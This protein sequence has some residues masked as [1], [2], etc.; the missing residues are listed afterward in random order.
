VNSLLRLRHYL[1]PYAG[2]IL[3]GIFFSIIVA[4]ATGGVAALIKPMFNDVFYLGSP[5]TAEAEATKPDSPIPSLPGSA[6]ID[7]WQKAGKEWVAVKAREW[8]GYDPSRAFIYIPTLFVLVFLVKSL[9]TFLSTYRLGTVGLRAVQDV[10]TKLYE[11]IQRQSLKFFAHHPTGLLIS[12]VTS[13]VAILQQ[14]LGTP[15][16]EIIRL[17]F[18]LVFLIAAALF[19]DWKLS[20]ICTVVIPV[21]VYPAM[22]FARKIKRST[23]TSQSRLADLAD[24][25]Q[26]TIVGRRVVRGF[27]GESYEIS[28]FRGLLDKMYV[29]DG[30]A[31]KYRALTQPV[32]ELIGSLAMA[33]LAAFAGWR[34][35]AGTLDPGDFVATLA[36]LYWM[37]AIFKHF[38]RL[39]NDMTRAAA[40]AERVFQVLDSEPDVAEAADAVEMPAFE[41]EIR[42]REACFSYAGEPVLQGIDLTIRKGEKVALVGASG[43]GK[44]TTV[45]LLPRFYDVTAGAVEIDG[46]DV[47]RFTLESLRAQIG[48]VTQEIVLFNDTARNNIAYGR[49]DVSLDDVVTAAR[50]ANAHEFLSALPSRYDTLLGEAGQN[51]SA[52]QRQRV[53]IARALLK[54]API[55]ILDEAT[56]ALDA[57]SEALVQAALDK[58]IA[59]RTAIIIA[60]RLTTVRS[61]DRIVVIENGRIAEIGTHQ[62]LLDRKGVYARLHRLQFDPAAAPPP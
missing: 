40:A 51:L 19:L 2:T 48:L 13:D 34:I 55:L 27:T 58:L 26:E 32:I 50:A 41:G 8:F 61:A 47:R 57:E 7:G 12:R 39:G 30:R 3:A 43:A 38:A 11:Q 44:T 24:R 28:R 53:A 45:N 33:T 9:F 59:D 36:A 18:S 1:R 14:I 4:A 56:S 42:F 49:P 17:S 52:G 60:H 23:S 37:Y 62:E 15:A 35:H 25:L 10:R 54:G 5:V 29:A 20:L 46:T 16:A 31:M 21:T 22:R 6:T